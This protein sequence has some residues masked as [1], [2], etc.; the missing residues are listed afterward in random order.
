MASRAQ[1]QA[2]EQLLK[3]LTSKNEVL[4][5]S[6]ELLF[7]QIEASSRLSSKQ[8]DQVKT[9]T[10]I[11]NTEK[12]N[13]HINDKL[14]VLK[15]RA[16]EVTDKTLNVE[17]KKLKVQ[18]AGTIAVQEQSEA[19]LKGLT[20]S[21]SMIEKLP[22]GGLLVG[23]LGLGPKNIK[24]LQ[25][26]LSKVITG[27]MPLSDIFKGMPKNFGK[28]LK[29]GLGV[30]VAVGLI[31]GAFSLIKKSVTFVAGMIDEL[32]ASF[33]AVATRSDEFKNTMMDASVEGISIGKATKDVVEVTQELSQNF[34]LSFNEAAKMSDKILDSAVGMGMSNSEAAKLFGTFMSLGGLSLEQA[35]NLAE[36]TYQLAAQN[37][38][39]PVAVMKDI[40]ESSEMIAKF[41]AANLES[42]TKAAIQARKM[43]L[44]LSTVTKIS[45]SLL[46]FQSSFQAEMEASVMIGRT[47]N[48]NEARRL[49]FA[50]KTDE[51]FQ[52][53]LKQM[54]GIDK[55][56]KLGVLQRRALAKSI[57]LESTE[58]AKLI[59]NQGKSIEQQKTFN[60]I[61]G[62][63]G[64]SSL[65]SLINKITELGKT[66][67]MEFGKPLEALLAK[68]EKN[69]LNE[70]GMKNFKGKMEDMGKTITEPIEK[71]KT[72]AKVTATLGGA[73][74]GAKAGALIGSIIPGAGTALGAGIGAGIGGIAGF[75]GSSYVVDDFQSSGGSHLVVTPDGRKLKTNPRDTVFGTTSVNDFSSGP[76][77]SL[78][79]GEET[80][81]ELKKLNENIEILISETKRTSGNIVSGIGAL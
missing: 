10:L 58:L 61:M 23:A 15:N 32:G 35:E 56:E 48:L 42:I 44:N 65:T 75:L 74:A 16:K 79:G 50:G 36:S 9:L 1:I 66:F 13:L 12:G 59:R 70:E 30:G 45:D 29:I 81:Q 73:Y 2:Q 77:G 57:G 63:E 80:N 41:G 8:K 51:A 62:K 46:D 43:G 14:N 28:M 39:A 60:D 26:N 7:D 38:V 21:I 72:A 55:F 24:E 76:M 4:Q 17:V 3:L 11:N 49:N 69:F 5:K 31:G 6:S 19:L 20:K 78:M 40:S 52:S 22:A 27:A 47:I 71:A 68:F 18:K 37:G 34:G 67:L 53:V 64:L 33:G 25:D 54:G